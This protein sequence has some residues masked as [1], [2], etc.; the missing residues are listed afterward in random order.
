MSEHSPVSTGVPASAAPKSSFRRLAFASG[1]GTS[2]EFYDFAIYGTATALVFSDTFFKTNDAWFSTFMGLATF[3]IGFL[4]APIGAILFG[5]VG[6]TYGRKKALTLTFIGMGAATVL[7]GLLPTYAQIGVAAPLLLVL[8]RMVHG[9]CR[10]G[11]TGGSAVLAIEHAPDGKRAQYGVFTALGSPVGTILANIAFA[12]V[13]LMPATMV[14]D[15][16]WRLPFLVGGLV[17]VLGIWIR[18]GVAESPVFKAMVAEHGEEELR[19]R[20]PALTVIR[21]NWR[22]LAL[23]AGV[24]VGLNSTTFALSIF[25]LSY[26]TAKAPDGLDLP[27]TAI[28]YGSI[29]AL[30]MHGVANVI[31]ALLSDRIGRRP[32]MIAG[33]ASSVVAALFIFRLA[34]T[35][36]VA[37]VVTA[38]VIGFFCTGF[39]FGPMYTYFTELFPREQRQTG[40]GIAF[41]VGAVLGGGISPLIANR[42]IAGTG[43]AANIGYYLAVMLTISLLCLLALPETAPARLA[44]KARRAGATEKESV[45]A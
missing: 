40:M 26:A 3:G 11:E 19:K 31:G 4:M 28:V 27:R 12:L 9:L 44:A 43:D 25:M 39:L 32:V 21:T 14:D 35:G 34:Q 8:C 18:K 13:L 30:V 42:I 2:L 45:T 15:W 7:I 10:G 41:H 38:L 20:V 16:A 36:T 24:N 1:V 5:W 29:A 17:L 22:R 23:A 6:D 37:A 33:A